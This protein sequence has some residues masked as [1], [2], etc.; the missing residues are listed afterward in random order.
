MK[1]R[2]IFFD[3]EFT[4]LHWNTTLISIGLIDETG[5]T[6]YAEL[7]DYDAS[8][9]DDWLKDNVISNLVMPVSFSGELYDP[10]SWSKKN[11]TLRGNS[12]TVKLALE[13]WFQDLLG[14]LVSWVGY[15]S[16]NKPKLVEEPLIEMW[17][18]CLSYDWGLFCNLWEHVFK[19]PKCIYYIPFDICTSFRNCGV[20]PDIN[21]EEFCNYNGKI[22]KHN[23]LFDAKIIKACYLEL[24]NYRQCAAK[25][26]I[27]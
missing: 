17:S 10:N 9:V 23:A 21:R 19:M 8:Q 27:G 4:G 25:P 15:D 5:R 6:F 12:E 13:D 22:K 18:D 11:V 20:D 2:K 7:N 1:R 16:D 24:S 14:G 3:T 26:A